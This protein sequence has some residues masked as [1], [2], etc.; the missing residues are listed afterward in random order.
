MRYMI[1]RRSIRYENHPRE[2]IVDAAI[3]Y[4]GQIFTGASHGHAI[5]KLKE[6]IPDVNEDKLLAQMEESDGF[7]TS[8][9][10]F[11]SRQE[12]WRIAYKANQLKRD[13]GFVPDSEARELYSEDLKGGFGLAA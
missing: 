13:P 11:V 3:E 4:E 6:A 12:G 5:G 1:E 9:G 2:C 10:R 7:V 8:L